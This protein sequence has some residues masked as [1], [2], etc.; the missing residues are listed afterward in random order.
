MPETKKTL[1]LL[2]AYALIYRAYYAFIRAPR[3]NSKGLNTSAIYGFT[4]TLLDIVNNHNPTHLAVVIDYPGPTFRDDLYKDYKANRESTPEDIKKAVPYIKRILEAMNIPLLE[5]EGFEADDVIGTLAKM[6]SG[7]DGIVITHN[8][9]NLGGSQN[10][11]IRN[12]RFR[13]GQKDVNGQ[14]L[15]DQALGVENCN[16][17]IFDH[18]VVGWSMEENMNTQDCHFLTVQNTIVH[19]GLYNAGHKKGKRGYGTQWGGSPASY[20]R[21][22]LADNKSRSPRINGARGEDYVVF[23]EYI[24]NVNYNFGGNGGCYGGENTADIT[25]YN[26]MNSAHECNFI[27]NYYKPGPASNKSGVVLVTDRKSVV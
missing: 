1:F 18:C 26:G 13:C 10:F 20:Y 7:G 2:D 9:I 17:Y 6:A 19:E 3:V 5:A 25:S 23:L 22:L 8:K 21:N 4:N 27:G 16:N 12:V 24:N 11:I 15:Q 14:I